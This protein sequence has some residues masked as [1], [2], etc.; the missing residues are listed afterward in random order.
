M[1]QS[2]TPTLFKA[3]LIRWTWVMALRDGR[4]QRPRLA[5]YALSIAV[6]ICALTTIATLKASVQSGISTQVKS[7]LGADLLL[8][9]RS[10]ISD[11]ALHEVGAALRAM[12]K[13][14]GFS[15]MLT[16]PSA[17]RSRLVQVRAIEGDFPFYAAVV[18]D[19]PDAWQRLQSERGIIVEPAL[20]TEFGTSVGGVFKLGSLELPILGVLKSG[21]PRS[22]RFSGFATEV[23]MRQSDLEAT[24]LIGTQ[25]LLKYHRYLQ[26][27]PQG[28]AARKTTVEAIKG[29]F[30]KQSIQFQ[31][32]EDRQETIEE[33]IKRIQEFL[34]IM[35]LSALVLGGI[36]VAGAM[37][38][39][40]QRRVPTV[41]ILLCLG[42]TTQWAFAIYL[43]QALTL[44]LLGSGAGALAGGLLH[45]MLVHFAGSSLPF[46]I[47]ALP[48]PLI[49]L[50]AAAAGFILCCGF[51]LLP[52]LRI[53]DISPAAMLGER[54]A[55][56]GGRLPEIGVYIFLTGLIWAAAR[57]N[58]ATSLRALCL[59]GA[60][61][62]AFAALTLAGKALM[63]GTRFVLRPSWPY[64]LRQ[65]ISNLYRP[66]NQ[67]LLFLLSLG[68]GVF[69]LLT[70]WFTQ[71][72]VLAQITVTDSE[73]QAN[74]YLV[75]VQPDQ[76]KAVTEILKVHGLPLLQSAPMVSM[77]IESIKG[78][79]LSTLAAPPQFEAGKSGPTK[80]IPRWALEREYRS[81]YRSALGADETIVAGNWPPENDLA[82]PTSISL[83]QK[84]AADLGVRL[85]DEM[86]MDVQ[87][88]TIPVRIACLRK[89]DWSK[90]NLNFFMVFP[91]GVLENAPQFHLLSTHIPAGDTSGELQRALQQQTPNVSAVDLTS[92]LATVQGILKK[93]AIVVQWLA[94]FT[95]L[96]GLP[97]LV[98]SLLNGK[99]HRVRESVLLRT[100]GAT[101]RQVLWIVLIEYT[102]LGILSA[103][104]GTAL[105]LVT[106]ELM[107]HFVFKTSPAYEMTPILLAVGGALGVSLLT[108]LLLTRGICKRPPL[109]VLRQEN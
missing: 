17:E 95:I 101:Q 48:N 2:A 16:T 67:T 25:S 64:L 65:G 59:T 78:Q 9:S 63:H 99:E 109:F 105:A 10:P 8:S 23:F 97:I 52:L 85:G 4:S 24:G 12:S 74:L 47:D 76:V 89:V 60:L 7:L 36:G 72:L 19:P 1:S 14:T 38:T 69:Q 103:C 61:A 28:D 92:I 80:K 77:R 11:E 82:G 54:R 44:G 56:R 58:G 107:A 46:S 75:D 88:V 102:S 3:L 98:G 49:V 13:E 100:L 30:P 81:T 39:H 35:G 20:L 90:F 57:L 26:L 33:N 84:L 104:A 91:P 51:A 62:L 43:A 6:G 73:N 18:T 66:H 5:L 50:E 106:R 29:L 108:G 21:V 96:A 32:P 70:T 27:E 37:H 45:G 83:E 41:A 79:P 34:G 71:S 68:L 15:S 31:T 94:G 42:C 40:I 93:A 22:G 55:T 53:R 86:L 87:G